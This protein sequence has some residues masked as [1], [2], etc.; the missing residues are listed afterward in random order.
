MDSLFIQIFFLSLTNPRAAANEQLFSKM[1]PH[2]PLYSE[3]NFGWLL[4]QTWVTQGNFHGYFSSDLRTRERKMKVYM[5][6]KLEVGDSLFL[7][8]QVPFNPTFLFWRFHYISISEFMRHPIYIPII[9][10]WM[11]SCE[12]EMIF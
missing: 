11:C 4:A 9:N 2:F 3:L 7:Y 1:T 10:L 12:I 8:S 6:R 5:T